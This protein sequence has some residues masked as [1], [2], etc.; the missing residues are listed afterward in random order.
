MVERGRPLGHKGVAVPQAASE[1]V[2]GNAA[3]PCHD[4]VSGEET[5]HCSRRCPFPDIS[6][7]RGWNKKCE[8]GPAS[9][10]QLLLIQ[11]SFV[12]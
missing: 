11:I 1:A 4:L 9:G 3:R 7:R 10:S 6:K 8:T 12:A 5:R 2:T